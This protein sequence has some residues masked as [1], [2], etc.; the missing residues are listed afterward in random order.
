M[1]DLG[2]IDSLSR[3]IDNRSADVRREAVWTLSNITAGTIEQFERVLVHEPLRTALI[4]CMYKDDHRYSKY[5]L[6]TVKLLPKSKSTFWQ[7]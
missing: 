5:I 1:L 6:Q 4:E 7:A 2:L 3:L